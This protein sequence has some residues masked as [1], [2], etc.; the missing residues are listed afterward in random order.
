MQIQGKYAETIVQHKNGK[1]IYVMLFT[2]R[3]GSIVDVRESAPTKDHKGRRKFIPTTRPSWIEGE[4]IYS[5][6]VDLYYEMYG[7]PVALFLK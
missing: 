5:S 7:Q 6:R 4:G 3:R 1:K 2:N